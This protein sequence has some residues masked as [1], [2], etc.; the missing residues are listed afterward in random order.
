MGV[1]K[2]LLAYSVASSLVAFAAAAWALLR[3]E[4][5]APR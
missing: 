4:P 3:R 2:H 1:M 5:H